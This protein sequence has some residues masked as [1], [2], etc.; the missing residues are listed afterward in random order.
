MEPLPL[1]ALKELV[2]NDVPH[3]N[4]LQLFLSPHLT[5]IITLWWFVWFMTLI[6]II[7]YAIVHGRA[8]A[9]DKNGDH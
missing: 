5:L 6:V 7:R 8:S 3:L 2:G 4:A 9:E 1:I